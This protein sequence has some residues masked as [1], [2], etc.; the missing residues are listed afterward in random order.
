MT[1]DE[2]RSQ[3][4]GRTGAMRNICEMH[5]EIFHSTQDEKLRELVIDA[6]IMGKKM[7]AKLRSYKAD[8]DR[9]LLEKNEDY[10]TD[11]FNRIG[12]K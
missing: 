2:A 1:R 5:R 9:G 7:D 6:Y 12:I 4:L 8:W 11:K 10:G 3:L